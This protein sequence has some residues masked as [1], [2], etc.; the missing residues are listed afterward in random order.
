MILIRDFLK[1][2]AI[3]CIAWIPLIIYLKSKKEENVINEFSNRT[4]LTSEYLLQTFNNYDNFSSSTSNHQNLSIFKNETSKIFF[5]CGVEVP[6]YIVLPHSVFVYFMPIFLILTFYSRTIV[7]VN[8]KMKRRRSTAPNSRSASKRHWFAARGNHGNLSRF[9]RV[10]QFLSQ[11]KL[12]RNCCPLKN[13]WLSGSPKEGNNGI[14]TTSETEES[15]ADGLFNAADKNNET[16]RVSP[17]KFYI[18]DELPSDMNLTEETLNAHKPQTKVESL[19]VSHSVNSLKKSST[20]DKPRLVLE[21]TDKNLIEKPGQGGSEDVTNPENQDASIDKK[22]GLTDDFDQ[23]LLIDEVSSISSSS[24]PEYIQ[25]A[26]VCASESADPEAAGQA[27]YADK[28]RTKLLNHILAT[29]SLYRFQTPS[30]TEL[31]SQVIA[32]LSSGSRNRIPSP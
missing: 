22:A 2:K 6:A 13:F 26:E 8:R 30:L 31:E 1:F 19:A 20:F 29:K 3:G 16:R 5:D 18:I 10:L 21:T 17:L 9:E 25:T 32:K 14:T 11:F 15:P 24:N 4:N 12:V 23:I 28:L 27:Y 7:I